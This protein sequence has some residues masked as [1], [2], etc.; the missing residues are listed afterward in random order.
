[1]DE[2]CLTMSPLL[3]A[4][5]SSRIATGAAPLVPLGLRLAHTLQGDDTLLLRYVRA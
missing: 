3:E 1:M 2:L 4:G 5:T